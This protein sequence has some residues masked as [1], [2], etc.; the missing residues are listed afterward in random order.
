MRRQ[1]RS[2]YVF[3]S[4]P[5]TAFPTVF[6]CAT[7]GELAIKQ[8]PEE[9]APFA[10]PIAE[11]L[12][13]ILGVSLGQMPRSLVEN[14]AITLGRIAWVCPTQVRR[15]GSPAACRRAAKSFANRV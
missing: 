3:A 5:D 11:R 14:A 9:L 15:F 7:A 6:S 13:P 2:G 12:V 10:A 4:L 1:R 8:R